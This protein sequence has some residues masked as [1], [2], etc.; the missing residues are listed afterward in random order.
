M[1]VCGVGVPVK[2]P[3]GN[4]S[5]RGSQSSTQAHTT[6]LTLLASFPSLCSIYGWRLVGFR[7][8]KIS[9]PFQILFLIL[10]LSIHLLID[11]KGLNN[12][13]R[14]RTYVCLVVLSMHLFQ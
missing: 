13:L 12:S 3:S 11:T 4:P 9:I 6:L 5:I 2:M 7:S 1:V 10:C 14:E 8:E